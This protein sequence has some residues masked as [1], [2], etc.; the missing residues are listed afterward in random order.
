MSQTIQKLPLS[1]IFAAGRVTVSLETLA[2]L[3]KSKALVTK[4]G[5]NPRSLEF[6]WRNELITRSQSSDEE[7]L[8]VEALLAKLD[9]E[10]SSERKALRVL[11]ETIKKKV[12]TAGKLQ[13]PSKES[14]KDDTEDDL[15]DAFDQFDL[16]PDA[17][18]PA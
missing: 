11:R 2:G 4:R 7:Q 9:R 17:A 13:K 5:C 16:D 1:S 14:K 15:V 10:M 12:A 18:P 3:A 6:L 8:V